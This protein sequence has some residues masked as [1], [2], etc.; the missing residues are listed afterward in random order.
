VGLKEIDVGPDLKIIDTDGS[1]MTIYCQQLLMVLIGFAQKSDTTCFSP[2]R[3][4]WRLSFA[5]EES[6]ELHEEI[7]PASAAWSFNFPIWT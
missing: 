5:L 2:D 4:G 1:V 6:T 3:S 7:P